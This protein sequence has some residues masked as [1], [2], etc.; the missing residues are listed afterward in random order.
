MTLKQA[1][2]PGGNDAARRSA[3]DARRIRFAVAVSAVVVAFLALATWL[4]VPRW[5]R[6]TPIAGVAA[7]VMVLL[8][9]SRI[10]R[11]VLDT[12]GGVLGALT[13]AALVA[14][15]G[16]SGSPFLPLFGIGPVIGATVPLPPRQIVFNVVLA[17]CGFCSPYLYETPRSGF[18]LEL[19]GHLAMW[20]VAASAVFVVIRRL[21]GQRSELEEVDRVRTLFLRAISHELRTPLTVIRGT[22]N[23][24]A[25]HDVQLRG[26]AR[27]EL[28][29]ALDRQ[30]A[31][32]DRLLRDLLDVDRLERGA[33]VLDPARI[34]LDEVVCEIVPHVETNHHSLEIGHLVPVDVSADR[35]KVERILENLIVNAVKHTPTGC[36]VRVSVDR[37]ETAAR[38]VVE[39]DGPGVPET[40]RSEVFRPFV[41]GPGQAD[42]A[43]PGTG[44]GLALVRELTV[45][46][47]GDV[48]LD[49]SPSLGGARFTVR[50]PLESSTADHASR[51]LPGR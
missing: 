51:L 34:R 8:S 47:G 21:E 48:R 36:R 24:L 2:G 22:T 35:A 5:A 41:Q 32:L 16:G 50:L 14:V 37:T 15:T 4:F 45:L 43:S 13:N 39:D 1:G 31:R 25:A 11:G 7:V 29:A 10:E 44:I 38:I 6:A 26:D 33:A 23:I 46:H 20:T 27:R 19:A 12:V 3:E 9:R 40:L 17:V 49:A 28:L 18:P 30:S 42:A